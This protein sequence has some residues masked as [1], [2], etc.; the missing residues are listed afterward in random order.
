[1]K[2]IPLLMAGLFRKKTRTIL[3]FLSVVV[4]FQLFGLLQAVQFAF[5]AGAETADAKRLLTT[6]RYSIIEPLP[7]SYLRRIEQVPGVVG[8]AYA[9]WFGAKYQNES[10]A[11]PVFAVDPARYLDMY[12]EFTIAPEQREAFA[13]TRTGAV[14]GQRLVD[15]YGWKIGQK[16]PISSEIHSK[17]DG[18][19][20]WEFD[21]VG[22]LDAEDPAV[23]GNTDLV[24][25]NVAHFDE[26]RRFGKGKT[27]WYIERVADSGQAKSIAAQID[28][29]FMNSPG[30][31]KTQPEKEF[32]VGFAKQ[33]GDIGA[34]VTRIL[35]AVFFTILILTGNTTAQSIRERIPELAI[36]K[37]LGFSNVKVTA[38]VLAEALLLLL[39][40]G[41]LGM[42]TATSLLPVVNGATGGR[43]P[44]LFVSGE[45]WLYALALAVGVALA[46]GLPPAL[47]VRRLSI[48]DA[49][50]GHR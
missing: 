43:F 41:G 36:L 10:N 21:L 14:A 16:L 12:P 4:A 8:V 3:T 39:I 33:I 31:T 24:L 22:I 7:I 32:A 13:K 1:V 45:T 19:L 17:A 49:L 44:P 6:A 25:I 11:F 35:I 27:G 18:D 5:E 29:M 30:E 26:A 15:R 42:V 9:D 28:A 40:G 50:A 47:R 37:T 48:V 46:I 34:L 23:R 20:N 38:L 2:Y